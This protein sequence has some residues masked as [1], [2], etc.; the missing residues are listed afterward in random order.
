MQL[1]PLGAQARKK[2]NVIDVRSLQTTGAKS[3]EL[4]LFLNINSIKNFTL[5]YLLKYLFSF[6]LFLVSALLARPQKS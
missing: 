4:F 5:A 3:G 2:H 1:R 6:W